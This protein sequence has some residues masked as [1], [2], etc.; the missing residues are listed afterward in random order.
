MAD[1]RYWVRDSR[2]MR[3]GPF[4]AAQL[5]KLRDQVGINV[6]L[7][8]DGTEFDRPR[9][10]PEVAELFK[11]PMVS[12]RIERATLEKPAVVGAVKPAPTTPPPPKPA[13]TPPP[14]P[15]PAP[16]PPSTPLDAFNDPLPESGRLDQVSACKL[17]ARIAVDEYTGQLALGARGHEIRL[18]FRKGVPDRAAADAP[19]L[20][21]GAFLVNKGTLGADDLHEAEG[22]KASYGGDLLGALF[23]MG[24]VNPSG[25]FELVGEHARGLL[26]R[27]L[28]RGTGDFTWQAGAPSPSGAFPLGDRWNLL[29]DA[30]RSLDEPSARA[31]LG[32]KLDCP[33]MR[34]NASRVTLGDLKLTAIEARLATTF[35]GVRTLEELA[36]RGGAEGVTIVK[37]ALLLW[38]LGIIGFGP[39]AVAR[40]PP[41]EPKRASAGP[42]ASQSPAARSAPGAASAPPAEPRELSLPELKSTAAGIHAKSH[43]E[44]LGV[45]RRATPAQVKGAYL[46][47]AKQFHPDTASDPRDAEVRTAK[48]IIFARVNDA[49]RVLASDSDRALYEAELDD[50]TGDDSGLQALEIFEKARIL[51]KARKYDDALRGF[52]E[53]IGLDEKAGAFYA[54]RGYARFISAKGSKKGVHDACMED[55]RKA[56]ALAPK[57][58]DAPLFAG[59]M[60]KILGDLKGAATWYQKVVELDPKQLDAKRELAQLKSQLK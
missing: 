9:A 25:A 2:G 44:V 43:F 4:S 11:P 30:A 16:T 23:A 27:A 54:W 29:C 59:H 12:D 51:L 50:K 26:Q 22:A 10:F 60:A 1:P 31:R 7:S 36:A 39:P 14:P 55:I 19:D 56:Q 48:E 5:P 41:P 8:L 24:R 37:L 53:A 3:W 46:A 17:Y 34:S 28:C 32:L 47:L 52:E 20:S 35:D 58:S 57:S 6:E 42:A 21:I 49:Y 40:P 13:P 15:K 45:D 33:P 18:G 38:E